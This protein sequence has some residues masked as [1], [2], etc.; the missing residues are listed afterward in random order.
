MLAA[1]GV[2]V[3]LALVGTSV[4]AVHAR[5]G[6]Q[7]SAGES[8]YAHVYSQV[9]PGKEFTF[10]VDFSVDDLTIDGRPAQPED[11]AQVFVDPQLRVTAPDAAVIAWDHEIRVGPSASPEGS[12]IDAEGARIELTEPDRWG[13]SDQYYIA[14]YRDATTGAALAKPSVVMFTVDTPVPAPAT[15]VDVDELG[16]AQF[17]WA[18]VE[19]ASTYYVVKLAHDPGNG[20]T[21]TEVLASTT[22]TSWSSLDDGTRTSAWDGSVRMQNEAFSTVWHSEDDTHDANLARTSEPPRSH[23]YGVV[24]QTDQGTSPMSVVDA[25]AGLAEM[26]PVEE[27]VNAEAELGLTGRDVSRPEQLPTQLP[28]TLADGRTVMRPVLY[29]RDLEEDVLST[30]DVD[31]FGELV[32]DANGDFVGVTSR[33]IF[34]VPYRIA[35]TVLSG[36]YT[37]DVG[38]RDAALQGVDAVIAAVEE[39]RS[40]GGLTTGVTYTSLSWDAADAKISSSRPQ[41]AYPVSSTNPL[42]DYLAANLIAGNEYIDVTAFVPWGSSATATG[43]DLQD[44]LDEAKAQ[45]PFILGQLDVG[46]LR[47]D[48]RHVVAVRFHAF[49]SVADYLA[50]Q[51]E[52]GDEVARVADQIVTDGMSEQDK[53]VAI[54]GYLTSTASYDHEALAAKDR[55]EIDL[56]PR[57]WMASGILLDKTGVCASYSMAFKVLADAAGLTSMYVTGPVTDGDRHAWNK[58]RIG[59]AWRVVDVTWDDSTPPDQYLLLTDEQA[60]AT[61]TQDTLWVVDSRIDQ[62]AAS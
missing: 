24:A 31:E 48:D 36:S 4:Y 54:N 33:T 52:L 14:F 19:G 3:V 27:A 47:V 40:K 57:A 1:V 42:T 55:G 56:V 13:L 53:V 16:G 10:E 51:K 18:P 2:P 26:L 43:I 21:D 59:D 44:A 20:V 46:F 61:R 60:A 35:G 17:S 12:Q 32:R 6:Q 38:D 58:V 25:S 11:V 29:S 8:E 41:V 28:V 39:Q 30:A 7:A 15:S 5:Q 22:S 45:N 34:H 62:Y 9:D 23:L 50:A 37:L 49:E